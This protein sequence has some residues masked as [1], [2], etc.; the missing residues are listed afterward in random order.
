M[1]EGA[2]KKARSV[3]T[4]SKKGYDRHLQKETYPDAVQPASH[5]IDEKHATMQQVLVGCRASGVTKAN[6]PLQDAN[7]EEV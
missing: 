2:V 1:V 3:S 6:T 4:G 5:K 7:D